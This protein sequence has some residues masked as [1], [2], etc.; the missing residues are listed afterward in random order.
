MQAPDLVLRQEVLSNT[1]LHPCL[2]AAESSPPPTTH[3]QI[4]PRGHC[5]P[6]PHTWRHPLGNLSTDS[7]ATDHRPDGCQRW[8]ESSLS[9]APPSTQPGSGRVRGG[10]AKPSS[11]MTGVLTSQYKNQSCT[12]KGRPLPSSS[13]PENI[14]KA[15]TLGFLGPEIHSRDRQFL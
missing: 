6:L 14:S 2:Q 1:Q 9:P 7:A 3:M 13:F 12:E 5:H 10:Q 8:A 11:G 15:T 4:S